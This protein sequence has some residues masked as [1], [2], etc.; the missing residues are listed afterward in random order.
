[1]PFCHDFVISEALR[2]GQFTCVD[3]TLSPGACSGPKWRAT[4]AVSLG[5]ICFS[6]LGLNKEAELGTAYVLHS[7]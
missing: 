4:S 1:V 6:G 5:R 3:M 7:P 2:I